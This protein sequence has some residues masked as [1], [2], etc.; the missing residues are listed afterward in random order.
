MSTESGPAVEIWRE[1]S[2]KAG[3]DP[4]FKQ[5][6]L[7]DPR[8]VLAEAG[9]EIPPNINVTISERPPDT[10]HLTLPSAEFRESL[11]LTT[12]TLR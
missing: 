5:R 6:L 8:G 4:E 2:R 11:K 1:V 10:L 12:S 9:H 3:E 7:D